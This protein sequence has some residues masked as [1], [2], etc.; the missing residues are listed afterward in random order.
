MAETQAKYHH[1][2]PQTYMSA[3]ANASGTLNIKYISS[4]ETT[5]PRNIENIA[6]I[7]D[8]HSVKACMPICTQN[9]T[10]T[11]FAS[12]QGYKVVYEGEELSSTLEMNK[13][14][15]D[16]D[17]WKI[18]RS[19]GSLASKKKLKHDISQVKIRDIEANWSHKY[20]NHWH[21]KIKLIEN[22]VNYCESGSIP[23]FDQDYL[24]RFYTALDWRGFSSS[25]Y[26]E[27][28]INLSRAHL[29]DVEIPESD[30]LFPWLKT[31][32]D[33]TRHNFL[34]DN[35]RQYLNDDGII[36][37]DA[38]GNLQHTS[39]HFL[40]ADG[41]TLFFT[42]DTPA[43]THE[44]SDGKLAGLLPITPNI[45][46]AKGKCEGNTNIY[47]IKHITE[48]EVQSYNKAI[49]SNATEFVIIP[50]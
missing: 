29:D 21:A 33:E 1:L 8:F 36:F 26:F 40:I 37:Q 20:E 34:L 48:E 2:I 35:F 6:G 47:N 12:L 31:G 23:A 13:K 9:D 10:D 43:F 22:A 15:Y 7:T 49:H 24:M 50:W 45:L 41:P 19:D 46:L 42:S 38:M 18:T 25:K 32:W 4:P 17:N 5:V 3:W 44:R 27:D 39:F 30:R 14:Y 16:F 11:I 28:T